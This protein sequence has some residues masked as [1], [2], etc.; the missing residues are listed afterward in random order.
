[1][2]FFHSF[3]FFL[4]FFMSFLEFFLNFFRFLFLLCILR[5]RNSLTKFIIICMY[6]FQSF[7]FIF[8]F[9]LILLRKCGIKNCYV[10]R[11]L[12]GKLLYLY[13]DVNLVFFYSLLFAFDNISPLFFWI[14]IYFY[15]FFF[16]VSE[17]RFVFCYFSRLDWC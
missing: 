3:Y 8:F 14:R 9:L 10:Q 17:S 11:I 7:H 5:I 12:V 2:I 1:M 13:S 16:F 15:F 4:L 6:V